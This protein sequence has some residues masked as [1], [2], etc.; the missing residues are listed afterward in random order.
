MLKKDLT[1]KVKE[2]WAYPYIEK[3]IYCRVFVVTSEYQETQMYNIIKCKNT[4]QDWYYITAYLT[5]FD[6]D[7]LVVLNSEIK[8]YKCLKYDVAVTAK[9]CLN[10]NILMIL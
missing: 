10:N 9:T 3:I 8:K 6:F 7:I 1:K 4:Y 5:I 2:Y